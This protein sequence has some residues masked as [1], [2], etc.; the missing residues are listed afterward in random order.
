MKSLLLSL[1]LVSD[2]AHASAWKD[3]W[4]AVFAAPAAT[5]TASSTTA[6]D[7]QTVGQ[8]LVRTLN[9]GRTGGVLFHLS[10]SSILSEPAFEFEIDPKTQRQV[11]VL[12]LP[13]ALRSSPEEVA[14]RLL[15]M[16]GAHPTKL[17]VLTR[18]E[19]Q[20]NLAAGSLTARL[21]QKQGLLD[22][23]KNEFPKSWG[24]LFSKVMGLGL[25]ESQA[26]LEVARLR[27]LA[28]LGSELPELRSQAQAQ[29]RSK[30]AAWEQWKKTTQAF[31][32]L[33][34]QALKLNDL[35]LRN[36]RQGVARM[37]EAY[38][39]WPLMEPAET[40]L[41]RQW[42]EAIENP[43]RERVTL[44]LRGVDTKTDFIQRLQTPEGERI[45]FL[46]TLLTQNQGS[47]TRRLR[48]LATRRLT[49]GV[50][51]TPSHPPQVRISQMMHAH[52]LN[53]VAS[54]FQSFTVDPMVAYRFVGHGIP[55]VDEKGQESFRSRGGLLAVAIDS[56]RMMPNIFSGHVGE[57]ELLAPLIV[58]PDEVVLYRE[59]SRDADPDLS[60]INRFILDVNEKT[61]AQLDLPLANDFSKNAGQKATDFH[62]SGSEYFKQMFTETAQV[63]SCARVFSN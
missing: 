50:S 16:A 26:R 45:A 49:N 11:L 25:E 51:G 24:E 44:G 19:T 59:Y 32:S 39:P 56:R 7:G 43:D 31:E 38:L 35:V 17:A 6:K 36:D 37:I 63:R 57:L 42:L 55:S 12:V 30:A 58:F 53:P 47:Y 54:A 18:Q 52:S 28:N 27:I 61:G 2:A 5:K 4:N 13:T 8:E 33:E 29:A 10:W 1:L 62:R 41:W 21:E 23:L 40:L 46:S 22:S 48:S 14:I 9:N 20:A 3:S 15:Q 34:S 60:K